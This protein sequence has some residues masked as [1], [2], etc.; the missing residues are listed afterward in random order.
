MLERFF[1]KNTTRGELLMKKILILGVAAVQAEAIMTLNEL[2]YETYAIAMKNDGPG[3]KVA[4]HFKEINILD[5]EKIIEYIKDNSIDIVY[6]TGSDLAIPVAMELSEQ[7]NLPHFV[8]SDTAKT[9]NNKDLMRE[10]LGQDFVGNIPFQIIENIDDEIKLNYPFIMKPTDSQGQ[11]GV[12]IIHS[13]FEFLELFEST[14]NYSRSGK[15]IIEYLVDGPEISVNGYVVDGE[16]KLMVASDR[17]TWQQYVGLIHKHIVPASV[18]NE[19]SENELYSIMN[20]LV[21]KLNINNGP[22]YAQVKV[23]NNKPYVIEVTPRLD[24]CHMWKVI[25]M[26]NNIDLM[27][28]T[29]EHLIEG[30]TAELNNLAKPNSQVELEFICQEPNTSADY[31]DYQTG[32]ESAEESYLYYNQGENIRPVNGKYEKIGYMIN[33]K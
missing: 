25:K 11:R 8:S 15:V 2:G 18:L 21:K 10:K 33:R 22:V 14:K 26:Y 28:L 27:K 30:N 19:S 12:N 4:K 5:K 20:N 7:L 6:S 23:E 31:D 16:L 24:G 32:I 29:F 3:S 1:I 17:E 13:H 9:T